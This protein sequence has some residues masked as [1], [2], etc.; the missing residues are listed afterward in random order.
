[1]VSMFGD[2]GKLVAGTYVIK[3]AAPRR[4]EA[5][6]LVEKTI[7]GRSQS[8][9]QGRSSSNLTRI[10]KTSFSLDRRV[11]YGE[12]RV[13]RRVVMIFI[14]EIE[15]FLQHVHTASVLICWQELHNLAM[16]PQTSGLEDILSKRYPILSRTTACILKP[17]PQENL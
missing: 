3:G 14:G 11:Q 17:H 13:E 16:P 7:L 5:A 10:K 8:V 9:V 4:R 2:G 1:M 15:T 6:S 12:I